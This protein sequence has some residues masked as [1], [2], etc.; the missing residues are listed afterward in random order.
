MTSHEK[1]A[2]RDTT[3]KRDEVEKNKGQTTR[4]KL[5]KTTD[6]PGRTKYGG[7]FPRKESRRPYRK[8]GIEP[9][10]IT[11]ETRTRS[12]RFKRG[13]IKESGKEKYSRRGE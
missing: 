1:E 6:A 9:N 5:G 4:W 8:Q 10:N 3:I 7:D 11:E 12:P 13:E 2:R